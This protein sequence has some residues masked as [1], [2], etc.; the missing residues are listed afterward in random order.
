[1]GWRKC[2]HL[3]LEGTLGR[4]AEVLGLNIGKSGQLNLAVLEVQLGDLLVKDLGQ[5]IDAN[6]ELTRLAELNVL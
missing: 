2:L 4:D 6:I 3:G 5:N 1:M